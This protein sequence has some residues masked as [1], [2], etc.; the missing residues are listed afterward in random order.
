MIVCQCRGRTDRDVRRAVGSGAVTLDEVA[1]A[2]GAGGDCGGCR[3]S[4]EALVVEILMRP[5]PRVRPPE[6]APSAA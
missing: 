5:P 1:R 6:A 2:C 4:V 3:A